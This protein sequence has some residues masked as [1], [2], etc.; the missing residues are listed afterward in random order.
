MSITKSGDKIVH[1]GSVSSEEF[2]DVTSETGDA[3]HGA[4]ILTYNPGGS[5]Y[6]GIITSIAAN[7]WN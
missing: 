7:P 6:S 1:R 3:P 5:I 2:K 4:A